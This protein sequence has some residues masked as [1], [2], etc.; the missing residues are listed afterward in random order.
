[1]LLWFVGTALAAMWF[2][3]RDPAIDHRLVVLGAVLPDAID[4]SIR[5]APILH[6]LAAPIA[7][8]MGLMICTIGRRRVRRR[9][10]AIPIGLFWHLVFDGAWMNTEVFWWPFAGFSIGDAAISLSGRPLSV[11][12][13]MEVAGLMLFVWS[14][15]LMGLREPD[16]RKLFLRT[17]HLDPALTNNRTR[18]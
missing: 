5:G 16:R 12:I 17:G 15:Y 7:L 2:T 18:S 10:L 14:L 9:G 8:M 3:F 4:G 11:V 13:A 6:T 1:M